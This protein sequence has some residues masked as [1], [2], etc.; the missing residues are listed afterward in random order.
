M[1]GRGGSGGREGDHVHVHHMTVPGARVAVALM[2]SVMIITSIA[3]S[4]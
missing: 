1:R 3:V 4:L 2:A